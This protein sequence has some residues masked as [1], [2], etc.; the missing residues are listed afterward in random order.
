MIRIFPPTTPPFS[1]CLSRRATWIQAPQG[2]SAGGADALTCWRPVCLLHGPASARRAELLRLWSA[3]LCR[4]TNGS[5]SS[6]YERSSQSGLRRSFSFAADQKL[7]WGA[8]LRFCPQMLLLLPK[9]LSRSSGW[10]SLYDFLSTKS[11]TADAQRCGHSLRPLLR[12]PTFFTFHVAGRNARVCLS[13]LRWSA[14][15]SSA[16]HAQKAHT[17]E[18]HSHSFTPAQAA[19]NTSAERVAACARPRLSSDGASSSDP[20]PAV[21]L[22]GPAGLWGWQVRGVGVGVSDVPRLVLPLSSLIVHR[23]HPLAN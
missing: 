13:L 15:P 23:L 3:G 12:A 10:S 21:A 4:K 18:K 9:I 22:D 6:P 16:A 1:L 8:S 11:S 2:A 17:L 20:L 14:W 5:I 7:G 19:Q